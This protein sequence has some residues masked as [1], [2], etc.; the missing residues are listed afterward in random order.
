MNEIYARRMMWMDEYIKEHVADE[1]LID[2]WLASGV[3]DGCDLES[4]K[5]LASF[6]NYIDCCRVFTYILYYNDTGDDL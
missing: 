4:C 5:E 6:D 3:P 2:Y 1:D